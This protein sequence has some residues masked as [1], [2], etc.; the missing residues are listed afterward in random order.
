MSGARARAILGLAVIGAGAWY[1]A[2]VASGTL[3]A[4]EPAAGVKAAEPGAAV[5]KPLPASR[6]VV[7]KLPGGR[8]LRATEEG[9]LRPQRRFP[10]EEETF[11]LLKRDGGAIALRAPGGRLLTACGYDARTLRADS[12]RSEPGE[13]ETLVLV[14]LDGNR[15]GMKVR[16]LRDFILFA[17]DAPQVPPAGPKPAEKPAAGEIVEIYEAAELPESIRSMLAS[18]VQTLAAEELAD[19]EY[20]RVRSHKREKFLDLPAPSKKDLLRTKPRRVW[21]VTEEY[22]VRARLDGPME[23]E[24][25]HMPYLKGYGQRDQARLMFVVH[26]GIPVR[27]HVRYAIPDALSVSTGFR[28]TARLELVG[29][30]AARKSGDELSLGPP[31]VLE[32]HVELRRLDLSNDVLQAVRE[33]IEELVNRELRHNEERIRS[34]ANKSLAK[35]FQ[36]RQLH[37]PLLRYLALP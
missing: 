15:V 27:G 29:E 17:A 12:P 24:I 13:R 2:A 3:L 5:A 21:S 31:G 20:N 33:P 30:L 28:T 35:A 1:L 16:G 26:A 11:E 18:A 19:K 10:T 23:I 8:F 37:S 25:R 6:S 7:L 22:Q 36:A 9:S 34:Q 4:A 14:P 32:L